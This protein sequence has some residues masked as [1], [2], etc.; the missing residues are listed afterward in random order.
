MKIVSVETFL[1]PPRWLFCRV[2]TD[3]G[4]VGWGEPVVEGRAET[5]RAAVDELSD[6]LLGRDPRR[7]EDLWQVMTKA[8]FYRGGPVLSSAVAGIDQ[9]LWDILG[10]S[11]GVPV[12]Q[13]LGGAVRDEVR[14]YGW[15]GGDEPSA[16]AEAAAAQAEAGLTAVK[17]NASGRIGRMPN[18]AEVDE[19]VSR[20]AAV[21]EVLGD[22]RDMAVDFHGRFGVAA[23][24]R[25]IP[26]LA[27]LHPL[28]VEEPVLPEYAHRLG[29]V[30]SA[31]AVPV[32]CG[33]RLY[34]RSEF[35]PVLQAG[36]AVVQPDLS[37]AGGISE[38]R[39]I[40]SLAETFDALVAP[41]CPLGPLSLAASLQ[42]AFA[43]P[44]FLIQEQSIGIHYNAG[45]EPLDYLADVRPFAFHDGAIRRWDA[46]G[47]GVEIDEDAVRK[48]DAVGH[49]WRP[50]VWRH[51][52]GSFAEW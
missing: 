34:S 3:D 39:R 22:S 47:L 9:A 35:L 8:A 28:F 2:A 30:V 13:L 33:E 48:A 37:H 50:P 16:V 18:R 24:R 15:I 38:V 21:R 45:A 32:A 26:E 25:V 44:N 19:V 5:V 49:R 40:A 43:T 23:A 14:V 10:K 1:V 7:V 6:L 46:P 51:P 20:L 11:L 29:D 27:P 42:V 52:D 36:V 12:H 17:M 31:S 41:H 4:L